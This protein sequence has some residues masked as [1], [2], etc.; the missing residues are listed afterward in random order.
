MTRGGWLWRA[1]LLLAG[2]ALTLPLW[3]GSGRADP[4]FLLPLAGAIS[5][6]LTHPAKPFAA[7]LR[8]AVWL[9]GAAVLVMTAL[10]WL[11]SGAFGLGQ[12][13]LV[14]TALLVLGMVHQGIAKL[15]F[16]ISRFGLHGLVMLLWLPLGSYIVDSAYRWPVTDDR[17]TIAV[18]SS[19]PLLWGAALG[20]PLAAL[21]G[22]AEPAPL[23]RALGAAVDL[24]AVDA[25]T[26]DSLRDARVLLLVQPR[27]FSPATLVS[28]DNW[29][30]AG[31]SVV[32]LT[33]AALAAGY[34]FPLGDPRNPVPVEPN[35]AL[36]AR[37]G[38]EVDAPV[39]DDALD[40]VRIDGLPLVVRSP[41]RLRAS[42]AA[43]RV[44]ERGIV[45]DCRIDSG[46][47]LI[48]A[49]ADMVDP[50][51]WLKDGT[52]SGEQ[53]IAWTSANA[54]WLALTLRRLSGVP[55]SYHWAEPLWLRPNLSG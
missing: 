23:H 53:A 7:W 16:P 35:G 28:I 54:E 22:D 31:G 46:R 43:C 39:A 4:L 48:I 9:G 8:T 24:R 1:T 50:A 37:W 49:D 42:S 52:R 18:S 15:R 17:P 45:A 33:D 13:G 34:E 5:L 2:L 14:I 21:R 36:L 55:P 25:I 27:A 10:V 38:L 44:T 19:L 40:H 41:G 6:A 30:R 20:D 3:I 11:A 26:P 32:W 47:A 29:V 51:L 12:S